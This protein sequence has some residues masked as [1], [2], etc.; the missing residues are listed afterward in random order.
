M[1]ETDIK[2]LRE[3]QLNFPLTEEPYKALGVKLKIGEAEV[4]ERIKKLKKINIIDRIG[5]II[6]P[7]KLGYIVSFIVLKVPREKLSKILKIISKYP[8]IQ[9]TCL[10]S[11]E[12]NLWCT[13]RTA[14]RAKIKKIIEGLKKK[15]GLKDIH[16]LPVLHTFK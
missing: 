13:I 3:L 1:D 4:I 5:V 16:M 10:R 15:T 7:R 2:I 8:E 12:Y 14:S 6:D 9:E 11:H